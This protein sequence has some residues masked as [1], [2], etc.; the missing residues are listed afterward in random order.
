MC[1]FYMARDKPWWYFK[2]KSHYGISSKHWSTVQKH[3]IAPQQLYKENTEIN[4]SHLDLEKLR[5]SVHPWDRISHISLLSEKQYSIVAIRDIPVKPSGM[6]IKLGIRVYIF[7]AMGL[8]ID[9]KLSL[10]LGVL[11]TP[12]TKKDNLFDSWVQDRVPHLACFLWA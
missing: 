11:L 10:C 7:I 12:A 3:D 2:W 6:C 1:I 9:L 5:N 8:F 4:I